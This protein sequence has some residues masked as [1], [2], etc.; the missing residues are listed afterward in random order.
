[1]L[2]TTS[3]GLRKLINRKTYDEFSRKKNWTRWMQND[4]SALLRI[5]KSDEQY[6][7]VGKHQIELDL[8]LVLATCQL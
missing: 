2:S 8:K 4:T 3:E 1:M 5:I 6:S 7:L